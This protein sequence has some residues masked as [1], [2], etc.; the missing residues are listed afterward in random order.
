MSA[1]LCV[2][3]FSFRVSFFFFF[4]GGAVVM[5][6]VNDALLFFKFLKAKH[7]VVYLSACSI[8]KN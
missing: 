2:P 6:Y 7:S 4:L 8:M 3:I 5:G 1:Y